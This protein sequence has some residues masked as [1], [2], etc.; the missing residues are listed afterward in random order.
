M[1]YN[2]IK[3][4]ES[5]F[6]NISEF[7]KTNVIS[8]NYLVET[9]AKKTG[10]IGIPGELL[11]STGKMLSKKGVRLFMD[12]AFGEHAWSWEA[13]KSS[14]EIAQN[15]RT[16]E[17]QIN[18]KVHQVAKLKLEIFEDESG[19]Q[20]DKASKDYMKLRYREARSRANISK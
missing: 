9:I 14:L 19:D 12:T 5:E 11:D 10:S 16:R 3:P 17:E 8:M 20:L 1:S 4:I 13:P 18:K 6:V 2:T 15:R 7:C